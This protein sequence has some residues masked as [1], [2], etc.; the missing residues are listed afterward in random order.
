[1]S[2]LE[3]V[4]GNAKLVE[5][6]RGLSLV[7][8]DLVLRGDFTRLLN[9]IRPVN[10]GR[11]LLVKAAKPRS[12]GPDPV[13]VDATAGLGEDALLLA[14]A[15]FSV[16][17]IERN[18]QVAALLRDALRRGRENPRLAPAIARME[19]VEGDSLEVL[20]RLDAPPDLILL[21]P[22]FPA[23]RKSAASKKKMQLFQHL[24]CPCDVEEALLHA[25]IAA[26]PRK[27]IVKRP[28]RGPHLAGVKPAYAITGK[29]VR[30]D[31]IVLPRDGR[32][33]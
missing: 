11:E 17:L 2:D 32:G 14:A 10:L 22:M 24:E 8:G 18:P 33:Q 15:G 28:V 9:R 19:L 7:E 1:M 23:R 26:R 21:D 13:A 12:L 29:T 30:Y 27:V 3:L 31:C 25:A 4:E 20:P 6:E 16:R 5:D